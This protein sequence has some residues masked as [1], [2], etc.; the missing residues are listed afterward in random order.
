MSSNHVSKL[1]SKFE[2]KDDSAEKALELYANTIKRLETVFKDTDT[3]ELH[4]EFLEILEIVKL[5]DSANAAKLYD[6][7]MCFITGHNTKYTN[8]LLGYM[9]LYGYGIKGDEKQAITFFKTAAEN[10]NIVAMYNL[11]YIY[12]SKFADDEANYW[13]ERAGTAKVEQQNKKMI[14]YL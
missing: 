1:V 13:M 7:T 4:D 12:L 11:M 2:Q 14:N 5:M 6:W 10:G 9:N 3:L 8:Y